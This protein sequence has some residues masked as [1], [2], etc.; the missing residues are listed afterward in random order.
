MNSEMSQVN[1]II[2]ERG[3]QADFSIYAV[4]AMRQEKI[5]DCMWS[6]DYD[7]HIA[8]EYTFKRQEDSVL[9]TL[10]QKVEK[11]LTT[12]ICKI[13]S[14]S[15]TYSGKCRCNLRENYEVKSEAQVITKDTSIASGEPET[16]PN[17][18]TVIAIVIPIVILLS[19]IILTLIF[20]KRLFKWC[21]TGQKPP[22]SERCQ[23]CKDTHDSVGPHE[24]LLSID[25]CKIS[26]E[27]EKAT[28]TK[29]TYTRWHKSVGC[30]YFSS[31]I[32]LIK[33]ER[34]NHPSS[35]TGSPTKAT[36]SDDHKTSY[37]DHSVIEV[38]AK[39]IN[40]KKSRDCA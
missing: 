7:C 12:F 10:A 40:L 28:G 23:E 5:L 17:D 27:A 16:A 22:S 13:L 8:A 33:S 24:V 37:I 21:T 11:E 20:R 34:S 3:C 14:Q 15:E 38:K 2:P 18:K 9:I 29:E 32:P 31:I 4:S 1:F 25:E 30:G 26:Q 39:D 36:S 19:T 35:Q 6:D